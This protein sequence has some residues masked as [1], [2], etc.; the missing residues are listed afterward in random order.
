MSEKPTFKLAISILT[1]VLGALTP[2]LFLSGWWMFFAYLLFLFIHCFSL[3]I[4]PV[5][6]MD[7]GIAECTKNQYFEF[8]II[9]LLDLIISIYPWYYFAKDMYEGG[10]IVSLGVLLAAFC[11]ACLIVICMNNFIHYDKKVQ[12]LAQAKEV[13]EQK[14]KAKQERIQRHN[15]KEQ[16]RKDQLDQLY[17]KPDNVIGFGIDGH[18]NDVNSSIRVYCEKKHV[19]ILGKDY[20]FK[21]IIACSINDRP[22]TIGGS[23]TATTTSNTGSMIGRGVVGGALLG[24]PG[25]IIGG[26]TGK[27]NTTF[28]STPDIT[29]HHFTVYISVNNL[30]DPM[31]S[32]STNKAGLANRI[33]A[34]MNALINNK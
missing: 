1:L 25:A 30:S 18:T 31:I 6:D 8:S 29:V 14:E 32:I 26:A 19:I 27:K 23:T 13:A 2:M 17:G 10:V 5:M 15:E 3:A 9:Y 22:K 24:A 28:V 4:S 11:F 7:E 20:E 16:S 34:L 33:V 21:D 12:E